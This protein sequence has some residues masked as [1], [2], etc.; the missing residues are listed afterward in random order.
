MITSFIA[1]VSESTT[2]GGMGVVETLK[3]GA[4]AW[5]VGTIAA[6][7]PKAT[8]P[9]GMSDEYIARVRAIAEERGL[10]IDEDPTNW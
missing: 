10:D 1:S 8:K 5:K 6:K 3:K 7:Q 4:A 9:S 2:R